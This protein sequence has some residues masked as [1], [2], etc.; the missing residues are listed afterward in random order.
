[1]SL[2]NILS[3]PSKG[4]QKL[5]S[6]LGFIDKDGELQTLW[7][8]SNILAIDRLGLSDHG[9]VHVKIVANGALKMLRLL[10]EKSVEPNIKTDYNMSVEDAEVVVV[11]ASVMHDLGMAYIREGHEV[12]SVPIANEIIRGCKP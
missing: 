1:M 6:I 9:P 2:S 4:N 5:E 11:L 10:T 8:C 12:F 3:I 7:R